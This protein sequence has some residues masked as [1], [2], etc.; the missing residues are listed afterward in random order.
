MQYAI[1]NQLVKNEGFASWVRAQDPEWD[2]LS[3]LEVALPQIRN[4]HAH[5]SHS[6]TPTAL[7][8]MELVQKIINQLFASPVD[9][10]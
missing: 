4:D 6:L 8:I 10:S 2:L 7:S 1:D 5:G 3:S 9:V